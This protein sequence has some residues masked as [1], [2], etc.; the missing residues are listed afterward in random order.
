MSLCINAT[1]AEGMIL[2][3]DSRQ[4]YRN[5]K[6]MAR[7]G[8]DS[9]TKVFQLSSCVGLAVAG[10]AFLPEDGMLKNISNFIEE[11]TVEEKPEKLRIK[12][13]A[14]RLKVF[15]EEKYQYENQ[16]DLLPLQIETDLKARG[17][18]IEKIEKRKTHIEFSFKTPDGLINKGVAGIDQL[19]FL[20]AGY[21]EDLSHAVYEVNIPG[22]SPEE[23]RNSIK[24]GS[25]FGASWIGQTD[26]LTRIVLGFDPRIGNLSLVQQATAQFGESSIKQQ[27]RGLEYVIQWGTMTL[28]DAIDFCKLAIET[29]SAIQRFSDGIQADPGD[30]PGVG[31]PVDIAVITPKKGFVWVAKK[32]LAIDEKQIDLNN[33]DDIKIVKKDKVRNGNSKNN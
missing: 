20:I 7:I 5:Q 14:D 19:Q 32:N 17:F 25:E 24:R 23:R 26:V 13:I 1:T 31:G 11:F 15:F 2:A 3:A 30:M 21:D 33:F 9:A 22:K 28:Q 6:G 4:S 10:I 27:L 12:E 18:K 8:S 16:L 29:T